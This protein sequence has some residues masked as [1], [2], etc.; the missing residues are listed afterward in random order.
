LLGAVLLEQHEQWSTG[1]K[2]LDMDEYRQ[3]CA[4]R[5]ATKKEG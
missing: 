5:D 4:A 2:Y 3:W 1:R